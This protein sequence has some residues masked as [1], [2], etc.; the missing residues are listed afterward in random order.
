MQL[1]LM[2]TVAMVLAGAA[3]SAENSHLVDFGY[4]VGRSDVP[5]SVLV[6]GALVAGVLIGAVTVTLGGA[7][8]HRRRHATLNRSTPEQDND[9]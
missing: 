7:M 1:Y 3:L 9:A 6:V 5:L 8:R 2:L 4:V